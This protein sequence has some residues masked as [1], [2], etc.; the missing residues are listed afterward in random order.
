MSKSLNPFTDIGAMK[1]FSE[2][3][4]AKFSAQDR[5]AYEDSLKYYRDVKN[6][7]DT[8]FEEGKMEANWFRK[9]HNNIGKKY[10]CGELTR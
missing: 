2:A 4:I 9:R 7:L 6:S 8:A 3:E 1:L 5:V 10:D